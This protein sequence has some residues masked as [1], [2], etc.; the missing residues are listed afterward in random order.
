MSIAKSSLF[1]AQ[2]WFYLDLKL[3]SVGIIV[4]STPMNFLLLQNTV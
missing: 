1:D 4:Y 2:K 3:F